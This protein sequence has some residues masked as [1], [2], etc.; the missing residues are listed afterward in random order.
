MEIKVLG[1]YGGEGP[2]L[3]SSCL[4]INNRIALDAGALTS[5][6]SLSDQLK[7]N[8]ILVSHTH[9]D[10]I[11]DLGFIADNVFGKRKEPIR[12]LALAK[13]LQIIQKHIMNNRVWPD[14]SKIPSPENPVLVYQSLKIG[15]EIKIEGLSVR[16]IPVNHPVPSAAFIVSDGKSTFIYTGD[17]GATERLW[18][19]ANKT[20]GL[21]LV[22][23]EVSFP[24]RLQSLAELT[25][26]LTPKMA[27]AELKK[28]ELQG[29]QARAFHLKPNY[30]AELKRELVRTKPRIIP[31]EQGEIIEL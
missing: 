2:G 9:L 3:R 8:A 1:A 20:N 10:H 5:G 16:P 21:R 18:K 27:E 15:E 31:L 26:H 12:I 11:Q 13:S 23:I 29:Y 7:V 17:S 19:E 22:V 25:G 14:F 30:L 4:L 6:L 28:L 24:N